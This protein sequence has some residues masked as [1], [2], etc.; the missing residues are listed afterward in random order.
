MNKTR[1]YVLGLPIDIV[2]NNC[3]PELIEELYRMP[4]NKQILLLNFHDFMK[5]QFNLNFRKIVFNSA[6]ILPVSRKIIWAAKFLRLQKP[7]LYYPYDFIIRLLGI[8]EE[9]SH[10]VYL[11]CSDSRGVKRVESTVR[12]T[13][14]KI[15]IVGRYTGHFRTDE[16]KDIITAIKKSSPALLLAGKSLKRRQAWLNDKA[17]QINTGISI[18]EGSFADVFAGRKQ[19]PN[20]ECYNPIRGLFVLIIKPWRI[21]RI[22]TYIIFYIRVFFQRI[23]S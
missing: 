12:N 21:F 4:G 15:R 22:F 14:P 18:W 9:K 8:L 10:S 1:I 2:N 19:K 13:F 17:N 5:A 20:Y 7:Y 11:L 16:A 3:L 23:F 6:L